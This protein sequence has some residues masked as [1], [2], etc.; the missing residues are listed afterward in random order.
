MT[1]IPCLLVLSVALAC[2]TGCAREWT[3]PGVSTQEFNAD[4]LSC[5]QDAMRAYPVVHEPVA[6]YRPAASSK[7][8][9]NCVAQ[10]GL[11]N[12]DGPG[13]AGTTTSAAQGDPNAYNRDAAVRAC[14]TSLGYKYTKADR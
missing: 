6:S 7:L 8:D 9:P 5:E 11:N 14:L 13:P 1:R 10:S 3:K 2:V 4:R 12:C